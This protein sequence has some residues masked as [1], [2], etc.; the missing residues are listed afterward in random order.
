MNL[1]NAPSGEGGWATSPAPLVFSKGTMFPPQKNPVGNAPPAPPA[2][3]KKG[4]P[5]GKKGKSK[6]AP[7]KARSRQAAMDAIGGLGISGY[8]P[9]D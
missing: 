1:R 7:P 2:G 4:H 5:F 6:K 8:G 9:N 3:K